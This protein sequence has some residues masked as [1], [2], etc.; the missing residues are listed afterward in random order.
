MRLTFIQ[1]PLFTHHWRA[2][3]LTD[4]DLRSLES[5]LLKQPEAGDV[6]KGAGGLRKTRFAPESSGKGKSGSIRVCYAYYPKYDRVYLMTLYGK[7]RKWDLTPAE[8]TTIRSLL[9]RLTA[10]L[11]RGENP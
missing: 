1:F 5:A 4:D 10:A 3:G 2:M 7:N 8:V 9:R 6:V 11:A